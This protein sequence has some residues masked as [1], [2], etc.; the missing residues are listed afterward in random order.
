[1]CVV[2]VGELVSVLNCVC[3]LSVVGAMDALL[4]VYI[5]QGI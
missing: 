2:V 1:V 4:A 5:L 3:N